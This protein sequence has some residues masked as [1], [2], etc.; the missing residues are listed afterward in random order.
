[1]PAKL[2]PHQARG[3]LIPTGGLEELDGDAHILHHL[4][5]LLEHRPKVVVIAACSPL[6]ASS[7]ALATALLS[8]GAGNV[9]EISLTNRKQCEMNEHLEL[10]D[11]ADIVVLMAQQPL[12]LST[13]IG[14]TPMARL[15][16]RRNAEGMPVV[17]SAGGAALMA[18][19]M[20][21]S[22][23]FSPTPRMGAVMLAP[24]LGLSNRVVID[25][26]GGSSDRIGRL[27]TAL[28]LNPFA[29]GIGIDHNTAAFIAPDNVLTV[30]GTGGVT[31]IDPSDIGVS[32]IADAKPNAP[33][34]L[35][36]LRL[37]ILV[38]GARFDLDFRRPL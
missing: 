18:E 11:Q 3:Y 32:S 36:N 31:V 24:G 15:L 4:L 23:D 14:G 26:G 27:L 8:H 21:A 20:L 38:H 10:V 35:T 22:G 2:A 17:G 19:H 13:L 5:S 29:I 25:Q 34:S 9:Q 7:E 12:R 33:I 37:H 16:R 30:I 1:M 28:A 6:E